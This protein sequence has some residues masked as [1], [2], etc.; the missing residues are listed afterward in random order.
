[1][2][3]IIALLVIFLLVGCAKPTADPIQVVQTYFDYWNKKDV[4]GA[5][6]MISDNPQQIEIRYQVYRN[7]KEDIRADLEALFNR[8]P[9]KIE[10]SDFKVDGNTVTYNFKYFIGDKVADMGRSQAVIKDGKIVVEKEIGE[11]EN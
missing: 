6:S 2:K 8:S 5:L 3:R 11:F 4:N 7:S 9:F 1:M 10:L